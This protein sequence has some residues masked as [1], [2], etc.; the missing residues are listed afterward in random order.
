V[1]KK[2]FLGGD[3][4]SWE[5]VKVAISEH[6]LSKAVDQGA[7]LDKEVVEHG[8]G[9]PAAEQA[10]DVWVHISAEECH[11]APG[12][13]GAGRDVA[14]AE[15]DGMAN[16]GCCVAEGIGDVLGE[17]A[18]LVLG[19]VIISNEG[20]AWWQAVEAMVLEASDGGSDRAAKEMCR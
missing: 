11:G 9:F 12:L 18:V 7:C 10:D 1:L 17:D 16:N 15:A 20:A 8:V 13:E 6:A 2:H 4:S 14:G 3:I 5:E 19:G